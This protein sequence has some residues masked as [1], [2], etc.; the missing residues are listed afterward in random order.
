MHHIL[1]ILSFLFISHTFL[2]EK[3]NM[4]FFYRKKCLFFIRIILGYLKNN[5]ECH[6]N[7][8]YIFLSTKSHILNLVDTC[9][10]LKKST[11]ICV[12]KATFRKHLQMLIYKGNI[13]DF[14]YTLEHW[15][16]IYKQDKHKRPYLTWET[17][18][19]KTRWETLYYSRKFTYNKM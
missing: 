8:K 2:N 18:S 5:I 14:K 7:K 16:I 10:L 17:L 19:K 3:F 13:N 6:L 11:I 12:R 9:N 1:L 4:Q 15:K